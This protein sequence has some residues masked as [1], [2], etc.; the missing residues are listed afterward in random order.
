MNGARIRVWM[1]M[2]LARKG[3]LGFSPSS[4]L[5]PDTGWKTFYRFANVFS[6]KLV[7]IRQF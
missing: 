7:A 2:V 5:N 3:P 4:S 6:C 1:G